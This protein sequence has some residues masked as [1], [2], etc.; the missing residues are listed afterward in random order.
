VAAPVHIACAY[1][2]GNDA[3]ALRR[4]ALFKLGLARKPLDATTDL[5]SGPTVSRLE[6]GVDARELCRMAQ[7][8]V[9]TFIA[10]DP[11]VPQVIVLAM[12]HSEDAT[13]G[14]QEFAFYNHHYGNHCD[15]PLCLFEGISGTFIT[16]VLRPGKRPTGAENA[17][18][19]KRFKLSVRVVQ[20]KDRV[21]LQLPASCPVKTRLQQV[22]ERL[23][24]AQ[25]RA[26][27]VSTHTHPG[28]GISACARRQCP[29]RAGPRTPARCRNHSC[30]VD[31]PAPARYFH[32]S[33]PSAPRSSPS[34]TSIAAQIRE[35][36]AGC[37]GL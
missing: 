7:A 1:E 2:D 34:A 16:A 8:F 18:I 6:N 33:I 19:L 20:Y 13:H 9:E 22:T 11:K 14:Q 12:D 32:H 30:P 10:S 31:Q 35:V 24:N 25:P 17:M 27:P 36:V 29:P 15:L 21:R 37:V 26:A 23:F 28:T 5:A 4:D 3:N